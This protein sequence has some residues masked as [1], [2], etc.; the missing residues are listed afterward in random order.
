MIHIVNG[1]SDELVGFI[2]DNEVLFNTHK[3]SLENQLEQFDFECL[4]DFDYA[5]K[6]TDR[7]RL[8]IPSEDKGYIEFIIQNVIKTNDRVEVYTTA[9]YLDLI[10]AKVIHP[11]VL[12]ST[13]AT[14]ALSFVTNETEWRP[15]LVESDALHTIT[16][17]THTNPFTMLKRVAN[18][19]D[20]ELRFR[21]ETDGNR[22]T[23][24]YVD[25]LDRVGAWGG[26]EVTF[27][28]DLDSIER[29]E[30][31]S[32]IYTALLCLGPED[33]DGNRLEV[34]VEDEDALQ[35]WGRPDPITGELK[36]LIGVYEPQSSNLDMTLSELEQ[37]GRTELNKRINAVI[38][39]S[40]NIVDLEHVPGMENKKIRFG[41]TIRIK[42]EK[43]NPPL[44]VEARVFEQSR[45]IFDNSLKEVTLGDFVEFTEEQ[46]NAIWKSLQEQIK[47][48][49]SQ[50]QLFELTYDKP[51]IDDK[52]TQ[53]KADAEQDATQK[54]EQ[55]ETAAKDH[56]D[57]VASEAESH[58][59]NYTN[60]VKSQIDAELLDKA[61]IEYVDG[62][63]ALKADGT[64]VNTINNTVADLETTASNLQQA[65]ND[66]E[67][68]L[69]AQGG[70]ITTVETDLDTV[71][72]SLSVAITDLS[73]LE[74][75]VSSQ[76]TQ[77]SANTS[78]IS[79][80]ANQSELDTVSGNV[81]DLSSE[82][83]ILAGQVELKASQSALTNLEGDV[84]QISSDVSSLQVG[85][86]GI[87]A[88]V[89]SLESTVNGH[90]TDISSL[91]SQ[92]TVQAGQISSKVDAT[93]VTGAIA[94]IE[95][96]GRNY[97]SDSNYESKTEGETFGLYSWGGNE[98]TGEYS[99]DVPDGLEGLSEKRVCT[100]GGTGGGYHDKEER[101]YE[102][103]TYT[104]SYWAKGTNLMHNGYFV[105]LNS[106]SNSYITTNGP[107]LTANW[108]R[109]IYT[110]TIPTSGYYKRR[111]IIYIESSSWISHF[112]IE[113]GNVATDWTPALEDVQAE[114]DSVYSYASSEINQLAG[115]ISLK[116][117][118]TTVD[119]MN[120][121]LS[122][123]ELDINALDGAIT[124]KVEVSTFNTLKGRV[125]T[126]ETTISQ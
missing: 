45:D 74:G 14:A 30:D 55:A 61:G 39:Y 104:I 44:Y 38:T 33:A 47:E 113:K 8:I 103:G 79:L 5:D 4:P 77:I 9:S 50:S 26:R 11:T 105:C 58:A 116:A 32:D 19:F 83:N 109:Y 28:K 96:G 57:Q 34:L 98:Q 101:Y 49:I 80:K 92:L 42:D 126:A 94:D 37:Y 123:A 81:T 78:A 87:T 7:N 95:V 29:S 10:K 13:T 48:K 110:I 107:T 85:V 70:R 111:S 106:S 117:D 122:T 21:T 72:G 119:S 112:Q 69:N 88:D 20:L 118:S 24:R 66:N 25:L 60:T 16:I 40:A 43:F 17:D 86:N 124:S 15:G 54:A 75:T 90:T 73:S 6:L 68:A 46:V 84:T 23:N 82:L 12:E 91:N 67:V 121:R 93:Y 99:S 59:N 76:G 36:H 41:N 3:Q 27:G 125:D 100:V 56:A 64:L 120:T 108:K 31:T 63:L 22:V 102:A 114:I 115:Q 53:V 71:E 52:D 51:T 1:Q 62:Q 89:S 65:V 97:F 2:T 18:E 35:R